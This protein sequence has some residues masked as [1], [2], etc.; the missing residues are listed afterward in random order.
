MSHNPAALAIIGAIVAVIAIFGALAMYGLV[1]SAPGLSTS[2]TNQSVLPAPIPSPTHGWINYSWTNPD[3]LPSAPIAF[4]VYASDGTS[5]I[6]PNAWVGNLTLN[7]ANETQIGGTIGIY[8]TVTIPANTFVAESFN[9]G[10]S[11]FFVTS[12]TLPV[13]VPLSESLNITTCVYVN[14]V[15]ISNGSHNFPSDGPPN[16][17]PEYATNAVVV[18]HQIPAGSVVT[19][20]FITD[21]PVAIFPLQ[22]IP[23]SAVSIANV[24]SVPSSLSGL[25]NNAQTTLPVFLAFGTGADVEGGEGTTQII[26]TT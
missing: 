14:G 6:S 5:R 7:S 25:P 24:T 26:A 1:P 22:N 12:V 21:I 11:S 4:G 15:L 16:N 20:G 9:I 8:K 19:V 18:L 10:P 3:G 2:S 13:S 17:T 23:G